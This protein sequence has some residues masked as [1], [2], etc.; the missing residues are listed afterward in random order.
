MKPNEIVS[1]CRSPQ[2]DRLRGPTEQALDAWA[3]RIM[4]DANVPTF[5]EAT[6]ELELPDADVASDLH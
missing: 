5:A 1:T 3:E 2:T 4:A 6:S